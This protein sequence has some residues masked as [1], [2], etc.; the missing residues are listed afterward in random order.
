MVCIA[1]SRVGYGY[2]DL[3]ALKKEMQ[4]QVQ[5]CPS[6]A[7]A[8]SKIRVSIGRQTRLLPISDRPAHH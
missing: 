4:V 2:K 6:A 5:G 8:G 3:D 1:R 7:P